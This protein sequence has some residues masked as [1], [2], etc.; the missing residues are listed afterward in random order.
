MGLTPTYPKSLPNDTWKLIDLLAS[1]AN[2]CAPWPA[3]CRCHSP[4]DGCHISRWDGYTAQRETETQLQRYYCRKG[5]YGF[6]PT[7]IGDW[8]SSLYMHTWVTYQLRMVQPTT[9]A[10][11]IPCSRARSEEYFYYFICQSTGQQRTVPPTTN[12][13]W[14]LYILQGRAD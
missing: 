7:T 13:F 3:M 9:T 10:A 4:F 6:S 12:A 14:S 5:I 8:K 11:S 2:R 1:M